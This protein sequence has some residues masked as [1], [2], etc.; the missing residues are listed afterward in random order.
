MYNKILSH[1]KNYSA[2]KLYYGFCSLIILYKIIFLIGH[3]FLLADYMF[4]N[5]HN[6]EIK[7]IV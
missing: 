6:N 7:V 1:D 5:G 3:I 4:F 2:F